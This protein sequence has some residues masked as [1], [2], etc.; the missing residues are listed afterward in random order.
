MWFT[1]KSFYL[2]NW[3]W[4]LVAVV[5]L[6]LII[7]IIIIALKLK[8]PASEKSEKPQEKKNDDKRVYHISKNKSDN[9]WKVKAEGAAKAL[10][11]FNTQAEAIEYAKALVNNNPEARIVIHKEDGS[12]RN[13]TYKK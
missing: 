9:K 1:E 6:I 4:L 5:V 11:L 13:L 10:K 7:A 3:A 8:T 2:P 12:F